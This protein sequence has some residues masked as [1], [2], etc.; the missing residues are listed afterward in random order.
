MPKNLAINLYLDEDDLTPL[1]GDEE[2][3]LESEDTIAERMKLNPWK[4]KNEGTT[5][6]V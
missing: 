2:V 6:K 1:E 4:M 5:Y 3:K